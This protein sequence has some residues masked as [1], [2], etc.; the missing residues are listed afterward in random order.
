MHS[1]GNRLV[2]TIVKQVDKAGYFCTAGNIPANLA[3][4]ELR[5]SFKRLRALIR[6]FNEIPEYPALRM[7]E[8]M[9]DYGRL[10]AP[11][12][13]SAVNTELF[14]KEIAGNK[15]LPERKI[16]YTREL[17]SSKN[18]LLVENEFKGNNLCG[19]LISYFDNA[20]SVFSVHG[21]ELPAR[22][23]L[24]REVSLSYLKSMTI[25]RQLPPDPH[26]EELHSL[27]KKMKRLFYQ[28]DFVRFLHPRYFKLKT[29]QLNKIND[30]L[31]NDHDLHVF[32]MDIVSGAYDFNPE[33]L[34]ILEN[35]IDHL[36]DLN[37][38]KLYPR[39]KQF[40]TSVPGEFDQRLE[41]FF[42]L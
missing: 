42:K 2:Q 28:L 9:R 40:F 29:D 38:L 19:D 20:I 18:K 22:V 24:Y 12:R 1:V 21:N 32:H 16:K 31:G 13:E 33:E 8:E 39:L 37:Q 30:Q 27:R 15:L 10:L 35:K 41:R 3:V 7:G 25:F 36:R 23:H 11:L 26:P 4:H 6:F 14:D 17:F 34:Y 5:K